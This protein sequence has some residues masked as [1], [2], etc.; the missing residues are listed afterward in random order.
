M[1]EYMTTVLAEDHRRELLAEARAEALAREALAGRPSRWH[2]L[3]HHSADA[4]P[5]QVATSG[6]GHTAAHAAVHSH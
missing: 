1:N 2:R 5:K 3:L 4:S 6:K